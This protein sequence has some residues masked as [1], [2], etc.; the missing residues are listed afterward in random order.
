MCNYTMLF[1]LLSLL[2]LSKAG[3]AET[4]QIEFTEDDAYI[5][6]VA[7]IIAGETIEWLPKN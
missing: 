5:I 6:Q 1:T 4:I 2:I 3:F 7:H